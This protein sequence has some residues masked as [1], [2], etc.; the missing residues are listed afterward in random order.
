MRCPNCL[1]DNNRVH[2]VRDN[3]M[4]PHKLRHRLCLECGHRFV[5]EEKCIGITWGKGAQDGNTLELFDET[6]IHRREQEKERKERQ[7]AQRIARY[8][9]K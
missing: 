6:Y 5:T 1:K 9:K 7:F 4:L 3:F 2:T 8:I